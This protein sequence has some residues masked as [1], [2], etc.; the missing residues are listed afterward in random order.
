MLKKRQKGAEW[1]VDIA[2]KISESLKT[3]WKLR[4]NKM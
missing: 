2:H 4:K 1:S 3:S